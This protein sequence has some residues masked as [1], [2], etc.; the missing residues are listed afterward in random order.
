MSEQVKPGDRFERVAKHEFGGWK[1]GDIATVVEP[2]EGW[3]WR[4]SG[5]GRD[6]VGRK[7]ILNPVLWRRLPPS[8]EV[9]EPRVRMRVR[10]ADTGR[11]YVFTAIRGDEV[12]VTFPGGVIEYPIERVREFLRDGKW[13]PIS[14]PTDA[15]VGEAATEPYGACYKCGA[16]HNVPCS[17][18]CKRTPGTPRMG[19][20][21]PVAPPQP[22]QGV[23]KPWK[24]PA[25][26][27][28]IADSMAKKNEAWADGAN[29]RRFA[30]LASIGAEPWRRPE[31]LCSGLQVRRGK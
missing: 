31:G 2:H 4:C 24:A 25:F 13:V 27:D 30:A 28:A 18:D 16:A 8:P 19:V 14:T 23:V 26:E 1:T 12:E 3:G 5:N 20:F 7:N 22:A 9:R 6:Y 15:A 29:D 10:H 11:V 17:Y 21:P